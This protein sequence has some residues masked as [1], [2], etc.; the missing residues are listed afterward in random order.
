MPPEW[1]APDRARQRAEGVDASSATSNM[2]LAKSLFAHLGRH[3]S[4]RAQ[5]SW[6]FADQDRSHCLA[7]PERQEQDGC[8]LIQATRDHSQRYWWIVGPLPASPG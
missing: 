2:T 4:S 8:E 1:A 5:H 6:P 7:G 3:G